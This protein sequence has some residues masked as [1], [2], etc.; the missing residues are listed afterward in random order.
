M[1]EE[2]VS[3]IWKN[4]ELSS[5]FCDFDDGENEKMWKYKKKFVE[6]D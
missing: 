4:K 6:W 5:D 3:G 2:E 1:E